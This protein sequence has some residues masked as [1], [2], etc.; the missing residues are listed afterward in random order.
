MPK[1]WFNSRSRD[2]E[3]P[4]YVC[5]ARKVCRFDTSPLPRQ[6]YASIAPVRILLICSNG[7]DFSLH[8]GSLGVSRASQARDRKTVRVAKKH[9]ID[10]KV[11]REKSVC[12]QKAEKTPRNL[13]IL[14]QRTQKVK[15]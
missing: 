9:A 6:K 12:S 8:G 10:P 5:F 1:V 2:E 11:C 15:Q 14:A 13:T 4:P 7:V 3:E